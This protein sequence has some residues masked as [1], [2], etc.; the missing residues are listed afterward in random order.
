MV[1]QV[2]SHRFDFDAVVVDV[3]I[4]A[5]AEDR[6]AQRRNQVDRESAPSCGQFVQHF[7]GLVHGRAGNPFEA[8][9]KARRCQQFGL[10]QPWGLVLRAQQAQLDAFDRQDS[11]P[12]HETREFPGVFGDRGLAPLLAQLRYF[13]GLASDYPRA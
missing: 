1:F 11:A 9:T 2:A 3:G 13:R 8:L 6:A 4:E 10:D 7:A 5:S 12:D